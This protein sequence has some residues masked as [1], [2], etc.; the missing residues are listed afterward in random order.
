MDIYEATQKLLE[1]AVPEG[2]NV[3]YYLLT[4]DEQTDQFTLPAFP[5]VT[6]LYADNVPF[7]V[8]GGV[9]NLYNVT[10][11]VECWGELETVS[12]VAETIIENISARRV[13]VGDVVF[14]LTVRESRD[15]YDMGLDYHHRLIRFGGVVD[16]GETE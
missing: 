1:E 12:T 13:T 6:Y 15:I 9:T 4:Y 7:S 14:T 5:A 2:V 3:T 16:I 10:L 8:Q 11:D